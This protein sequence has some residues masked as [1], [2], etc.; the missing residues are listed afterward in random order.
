[1]TKFDVKNINYI[2]HA[3]LPT[4]TLTS[5]GIADIVDQVNDALPTKEGYEWVWT[6]TPTKFVV[7]EVEARSTKMSKSTR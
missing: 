6:A 1:M 3:F 7:K 2:W 5:A 4:G